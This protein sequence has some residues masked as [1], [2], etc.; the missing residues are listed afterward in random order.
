MI[1]GQ[2]RTFTAQD[3]IDISAKDAGALLLELNGHL[4]P[5]DRLVSPEM[6]LSRATTSSQL[7][8]ATISSELYEE[9]LSGRTTRERPVGGQ[10][11]G[12]AGTSRFR[13]CFVP[14]LRPKNLRSEAGS[15]LLLPETRS[16]PRVCYLREVPSLTSSG[17]QGLLED[18]DRFCDDQ[19]LVAAVL[20]S[21]SLTVEQRALLDELT[22]GIVTSAELKMPRRTW[23]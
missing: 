14:L 21:P 3:A 17:I 12:C 15:R 2:S 5:S 8:E 7:V 1:A 23:S 10:L 9:V 19:A 6:S 13:C 18:L 11:R 20:R 16:C 22:K 4:P